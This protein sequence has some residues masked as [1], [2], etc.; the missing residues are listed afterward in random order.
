VDETFHLAHAPK[1]E[2]GPM[3]RQNEED[4]LVVEHAL[5]DVSALEVTLACV[6]AFPSLAIEVTSHFT[7][8]LEERLNQ[9]GAGQWQIR[10]HRDPLSGP[11]GERIAITKDG[12]GR[13]RVVLAHERS[14]PYDSQ[15]PCTVYFQVREA[16]ANGPGKRDS[17]A[18]NFRAR[19]LPILNAACGKGRED[20][21]WWPK[22]YRSAGQY[23]RWDD[24]DVLL[25]LAKKGPALEYFLKEL[26]RTVRA[27]EEAWRDSSASSK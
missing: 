16:L 15:G 24:P 25:E 9:E 26:T 3:A 20:S 19:L 1:G 12:W 8:A 5:R 17:D 14:V 7:A 2:K 21:I 22:W 23:A 27:V 4:R 10:S 18:E 11:E 6:R 13:L